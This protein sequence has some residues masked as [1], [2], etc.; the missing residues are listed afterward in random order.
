MARKNA[1]IVDFIYLDPDQAGMDSEGNE[2]DGEGLAELVGLG[3][4]RGRSPFMAAVVG[5]TLAGMV[6]TDYYGDTYTFDVA[7]DPQFKHLNIGPALI[8]AG[9]A[10]Y[11]DGGYSDAGAQMVLEVV[12][13]KVRRYLLRRGYEILSEEHNAYMK[14]TAFM[15]PAEL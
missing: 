6:W 11:Y 8:E 15:A 1:P 9:I 3:I 13:P 5:S 2:Y 14:P 4:T 10:E 7:V 12:N